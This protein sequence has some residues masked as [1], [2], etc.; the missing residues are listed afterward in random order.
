MKRLITV[1]ISFIGYLSLFGQSASVVV[2]GKMYVGGTTVRSEGPVHVY[3]SAA[4]TGKIDIASTNSRLQAD[5]IIFYSNDTNDGL[6]LNRGAVKATA[7]GANPKAVILRKKFEPRIHTYFSLPFGVKKDNIYVAGTKVK[8]I[9]GENEIDWEFVVF[10]FDY[11]KRAETGSVRADVVWTEIGGVPSGTIKY[12][13]LKRGTGYQFYYDGPA[14]DVDFYAVSSDIAKLFDTNDKHLQYPVYKGTRGWANGDKLNGW[15]FVGGLNSSTFEISKDN[16][17]YPGTVVYYQNQTNSQANEKGTWEDVILSNNERHKIGPYTPFFI[18]SPVDGLSDGETR[19]DILTFKKEGLSLISAE[20]RSAG[21]E[22]DPVK[23]RLYF[24]LA[25]NKDNTFDRFYLDFAEGYEESFHAV[26]DAIKMVNEYP[27]KPV[28]WSLRD[29]ESLVVNGLPT[30]DEQVVPVGFSVPEAG[31]YT[32]SLDPLRLADVRNVVLV[33]NQANQKVDLLQYPY[34]FRSEKVIG[35]DKR[36]VLYINSSYTETPTK[37]DDLFAY[38]KDNILTV[39]NL[40]EGNK[41]RVLDLTGRTVASG[42]A[43]SREFSFP[44]SRKGV[45]VVNI[46]EK[47]SILKVLNK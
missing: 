41:V 1:L 3:A 30:A 17:I 38:V 47:A 32:I 31:D 19:Y 24:V 6:L 27:T 34:S 23:D 39:K 14:S 12:D 44:L 10:E 4:D 2:A 29:G 46:G 37:A 11:V 15:T 7:G 9:D 35:D 36:F 20:F 25:S 33:D 21:D 28:V 43:S 5:T 22:S 45:Y 16:L 42:K 18:H 13:T 8:L 26:K 40:G